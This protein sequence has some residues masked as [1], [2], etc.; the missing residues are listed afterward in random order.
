[1]RENVYKSI[2]CLEIFDIFQSYVE[3]YVVWII[4]KFQYFEL[5]TK[6]YIKQ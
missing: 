1:M 3:K 6:G 5:Q 2:F 4:S